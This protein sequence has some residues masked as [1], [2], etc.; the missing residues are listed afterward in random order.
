MNDNKFDWYT[1]PTWVIDEYNSGVGDKLTAPIIKRRVNAM[2][3]AT[4]RDRVKI[5]DNVYKHRFSRLEILV[6]DESKI[7]RK[8]SYIEKL[9][10]QN[11]E[12]SIYSSLCKS[13]GLNSD[14]NDFASM[15][16]EQ[17]Y[18]HKDILTICKQFEKNPNSVLWSS[19]RG[20]TWNEMSDIDRDSMIRVSNINGK[21]IKWV[22]KLK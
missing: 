10:P 14:R 21:Y 16:K 9:K 5:A 7:I 8:I 22:Y 19:D 1:I 4:M 13:Y 11:F 6:E 20:K 15:K 2:V 3:Y 18:R 17:I 12:T